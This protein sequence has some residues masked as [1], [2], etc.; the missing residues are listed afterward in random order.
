M[1]PLPP[2]QHQRRGVPNIITSA[3][4]A[5]TDSPTFRRVQVSEV[6]LLISMEACIFYIIIPLVSTYRY[7]LKKMCSAVQIQILIYVGSQNWDRSTARRGGARASALRVYNAGRAPHLRCVY[8][9]EAYGAERAAT[10]TN[11]DEA[12]AVARRRWQPAIRPTCMHVA[13]TRGSPF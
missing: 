11:T 13:V 5:V 7:Q 3:A 2:Q 8:G 9:R 10:T 4:V 1:A 12:R 6:G